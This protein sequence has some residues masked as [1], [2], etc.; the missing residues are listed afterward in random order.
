MLIFTSGT[1]GDPRAVRCTH[2]KIAFPGRMLADRF[3]LSTWDTVYL[4]MPMFH[5]NAIMA[6]WSVGLAAGAT[7]ALRRRFSASGFLPDVRKFGATYA[8]YV[9]KPRLCP[10]S[11]PPPRVPTTRQPASDDGSN[12]PVCKP[13]CA[14]DRL[15]SVTV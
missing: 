8:N 13:S 3:G 7:I 5:S 6:A 2:G 12:V 4:S 11:S 14:G 9:G 10:M 1:S 15:V